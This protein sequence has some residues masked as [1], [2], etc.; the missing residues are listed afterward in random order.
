[1]ERDNE[2][3][4]KDENDDGTI[5]GNTGDQKFFTCDALEKNR[6]VFFN[7]GFIRPCCRLINPIGYDVNEKTI[8]HELGGAFFIS[9]DSFTFS[10]CEEVR[11][12]NFIDFDRGVL[13]DCDG[14]PEL[15]RTHKRSE[16]PLIGEIDFAFYSTCNLR[17]IFCPLG[18]W[19]HH[20]ISDYYDVVLRIITTLIQEK[21]IDKMAIVTFSGGEPTLLPQLKSICNIFQS[22]SNSITYTFFTNG[23]IFSDTIVDLIKSNEKTNI[24]ISLD[25]GS[26][27]G[28]FRIKGK[29]YFNAVIEHI[30]D[31]KKLID[32]SVNG[33]SS[34]F[35]KFII[36][37][38]NIDQIPLFIKLCKELGI[39]SVSYDVD[40]HIQRSD[41][42]NDAINLFNEIAREE[43][44]TCNYA[45]V[46]SR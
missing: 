27:E 43:M 22:Y 19:Y 18:T 35:L 29:D 13:G 15:R 37:E 2:G 11:K 25:S 39:N 36:V 38:E 45:G 14:C 6:I 17:C 46:G 28:Y 21:K 3:K 30:R 20:P 34:F 41:H 12:K 9:Y 7:N 32:Q 5:I 24:C 4:K 40:F 23:V 1:M 16:G 31:Y 44:I 10:T 42:I 33:N 8:K 26:R